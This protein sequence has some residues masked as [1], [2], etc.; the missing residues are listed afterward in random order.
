MDPIEEYYR[1]INEGEA[2]QAALIQSMLDAKE[3]QEVDKEKI[4]RYD[5]ILAIVNNTSNYMELGEKIK[6]YVRK[7]KT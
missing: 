1:N 3:K 5:K 6:Q 2:Q 4:K 7:N